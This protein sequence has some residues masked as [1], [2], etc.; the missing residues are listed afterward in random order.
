MRSP[1]HL[2]TNQ[3]ARISTNASLPGNPLPTFEPTGLFYTEI[4]SGSSPRGLSR[5]NFRMIS[6]RLL[7]KSGKDTARIIQA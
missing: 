3:C 7:Q 2:F 4:I 6:G 5:R 1:L